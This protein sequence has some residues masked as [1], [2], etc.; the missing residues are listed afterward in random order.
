MFYKDSDRLRTH[1]S[2]GA[3]YLTDCNKD[4][5]RLRTHDSCGAVYLTDCN[6]DSD[7]LETHMILVVQFT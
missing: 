4:S 7:R 6:K 5:D 3:V 1:D 2:C